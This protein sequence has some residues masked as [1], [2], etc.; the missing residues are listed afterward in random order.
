MTHERPQTLYGLQA[1]LAELLKLRDQLEADL[2]AVNV[3]IDHLAGA[4][5]VFD[6]EDTEEYRARYAAKHRAPRGQVARFVL[7][8]LRRHETAALAELTD[9]WCLSRG[10]N[11]K[12]STIFTMRHRMNAALAN[13]RKRGQID[14]SERDSTGAALWRLVK[15]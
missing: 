7:D 1:K 9:Q 10:M 13:L 5:R 8:Y 3:D 2:A 15:P 12:P 14:H 11:P 4:I 6:P